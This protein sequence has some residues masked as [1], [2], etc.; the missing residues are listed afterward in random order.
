MSFRYD[1]RGAL[2]D[3]KRYEPKAEDSDPLKQL[4]SKE[5]LV[6]KMCDE[7]RYRDC[8]PDQFDDTEYQGNS[9]RLSSSS[10]G[11]LM[12]CLKN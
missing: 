5:I 10:L 11:C 12:A 9:L 7:E 6:E 2:M 1:C 3:V 8:Q 4:T